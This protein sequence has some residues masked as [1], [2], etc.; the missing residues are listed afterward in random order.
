M[1]SSSP[2]RQERLSREEAAQEL[3][4]RRRARESLTDYSRAISIPGVPMN[5]DPDG[6]VF[7]PIESDIALHHVLTMNAIQRCIQKPYGRLMLLEPPGSAKSTYA[8]VVAPTW[9]MGNPEVMGKPGGID[10]LMTSYAAQPIER[11]SKRGRQIVASD[12]YSSIFGTSLVLGSKAANQWALTNGSNLFAAGLM[13]GITSNRCDLGIID[14]PVAGRAEAASPTIRKNTKQAYEDDFLTR[15]KPGAPIILIQTRWDPEDLAGSIL[16]EDYSGQSGPI[17]CRDGQVWDVLCIQAKCERMDDPLGRK[18][19]DYLW[20][21]WFGAEHWAIYEKNSRTWEALFQQRPR[22]P[23]G[24]YFHL[25]TML[26]DGEPV[27]CPKPIDT[28][29]AVIDTAVKTGKTNDGV[30][31]IFYGKTRTFKPPLTILDWD[32]QQIKGALL[33]QWIPTIFQRLEMFSKQLN[34]RMGSAGVWIEDKSSGSILIQQL[35]KAEYIEKGWVSHAIDN[36]LTKLGKT[37]RAINASVYVQAEMVKL[38]R[39]AYDRTVTFHENTRNHL[40]SQVL[41]FDPGIKDMGEDDL[42]D[43]FSYGISIGLG[44]SEGY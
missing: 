31:V 24:T 36:D 30:G 19:G 7:K 14:D 37:E 16:P 5:D 22:P 6:W 40:L 27:E 28:V 43:C 44:D 3:L 17:K 35:Q 41:G 13:G 29:Y 23:E 8:S 25:Q 2:S 26:K 10:V 12:E 42:L 15:L 18:V 33:E 1:N 21:E 20:P 9:A 11:H 39:Q 38:T 32:L 34:C 4:R